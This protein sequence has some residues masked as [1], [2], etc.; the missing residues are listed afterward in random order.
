[1]P[2][3]IHELVLNSAEKAPQRAAL[4]YGN[5]RLDYAA[6]ARQVK[7]CCAGLRRLGLQRAGRVAIYLEKRSETVVAI[8]G[9]AAAGGVFV[10]VNP[11]LKPDQ[12]AYILR[13]CNVGILVTSPE[14]LELLAP[15]LRGCPDLVAVVVVGGQPRDVNGKS[16]VLAW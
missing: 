3:L 15:A 9:A 6:L 8:F 11:L 16:R 14:R 1:M 4:T 2:D 7:Q 10:P 13:D 12:V 5:L